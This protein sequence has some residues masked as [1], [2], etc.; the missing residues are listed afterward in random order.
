MP[1]TTGMC[2]IVSGKR[3]KRKK[4]VKIVWHILFCFR[5]SECWM[6]RNEKICTFFMESSIFA[7]HSTYERLPRILFISFSFIRFSVDPAAGFSR[8]HSLCKCVNLGVG[9]DDGVLF[10][11]LQTKSNG[12]RS[13]RCYSNW[14]SAF[15]IELLQLD[16]S[17]FFIA[18][19]F[20]WVLLIFLR[21]FN[22]LT[23]IVIMFQTG[24][25]Y[26]PITF[27]CYIV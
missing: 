5:G 21:L 4:A 15:F 20:L 6:T 2:N 7:S 3:L 10:Y 19:D 11:H 23:R 25:V 12:K 1:H 14:K 16:C 9:D 17:I 22:I 24:H 13:F 27:V 8:F 18:C 26:N